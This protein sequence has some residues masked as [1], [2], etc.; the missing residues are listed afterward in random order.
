M[1]YKDISHVNWAAMTTDE[2][3]VADLN[4]DGS[5]L[6]PQL[7]ALVA[8]Q[9]S[10]VKVGDKYSIKSTLLD[11][12]ANAKVG[13]IKYT[14]G[15]ALSAAE[16]Q[17][18]LRFLNATPRGEVLGGAKQIDPKVVRYS[19]GVPLILSAYREY[20]DIPYSAWDYDCEKVYLENF[21]DKDTLSVIEYYGS[22]IEFTDSELLQF[23]VEGGT[24]KTG[25]KAGQTKHPNSI[26][27]INKVGNDLFDALPKLLRLMLCQTW[28]FQPSIRSKYAIT[29]IKDLDSQ[30]PD[31]TGGLELF[32]ADKPK[33]SG[34][35]SLWG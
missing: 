7:L 32:K 9:M 25:A 21:I 8:S 17:G 5:F 26:T 19:T 11:V 10:P 1:V 27:T 28:V 29:S 35:D 12:V 33:A 18:I 20:K 16:V 3:T 6:V 2:A 14:N 22:D 30:A 15:K 13:L 34:T 24:F 31:I 4:I 23:R